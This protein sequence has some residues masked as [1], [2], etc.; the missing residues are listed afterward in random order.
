LYAVFNEGLSSGEEEQTM[1]EGSYLT[2]M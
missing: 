1:C 2:R